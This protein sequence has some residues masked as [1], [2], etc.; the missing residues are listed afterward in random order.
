VRQFR[1]FDDPMMRALE[2]RTKKREAEFTYYK[3]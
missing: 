2:A 3:K 1:A